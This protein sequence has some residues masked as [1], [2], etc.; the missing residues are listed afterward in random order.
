[1]SSIAMTLPAETVVTSAHARDLAKHHAVMIHIAWPRLRRNTDATEQ[2]DPHQR[3]A[4]K[5]SMPSMPM[6][7]IGYQENQ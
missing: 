5:T 4:M 2:K 1:M 3:V 7:G 6:I